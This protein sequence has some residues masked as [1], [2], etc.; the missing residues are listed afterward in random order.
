MMKLYET[1]FRLKRSY[2]SC[3]ELVLSYSELYNILFHFLE[4][5]Q[6]IPNYQQ[7]PD[8]Q[9]WRHDKFIKNF[10]RWMKEN[11]FQVVLA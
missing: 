1:Y 10:R 9:C 4:T 11:I 3:Q 2:F 7:L 5:N 8:L 6:R